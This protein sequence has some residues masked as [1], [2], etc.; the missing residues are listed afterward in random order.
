MVEAALDYLVAGASADAVP[1]DRRI[2]FW[3]EHV[4][5]NHGT[6]HFAFSDPEDFHGG[7]RVQRA[8]GV[9]LVDFWS[10]AIG[11]ERRSVD[12]DRD[13]EDSLRVVVPTSGQVVVDVAGRRAR[14][15]PGAAALVS[16]AQ[17][18][19]LRHDEHTRAFIL[20]LPASAWPETSPPEGARIWSTDEGAGAVFAAMVAEV[21]QQ[22]RALNRG[23]SW[24]PPS[25]RS[26]SSSVLTPALLT[27]SGNRPVPWCAGTVPTRRTT[28]ACCP[29]N[30]A[31]RCAPSSSACVRKEAL[32]LH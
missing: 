1:R 21:A 5:A 18:F 15:R 9:Q 16:M 13:G 19:A 7:T 28:R 23:R 4:T 22:A 12:V 24:P 10:D 26:S 3:R 14:I 11:Y 29:E 27:D 2:D 32:R 31:S 17:S 6:L 20:S 8:G 30:S 25:W